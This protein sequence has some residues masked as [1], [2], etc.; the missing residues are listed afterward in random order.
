MSVRALSPRAPETTEEMISDLLAMERRFK[1][2]YKQL[3]L[4]NNSLE[5]LKVRL[6]RAVKQGSKCFQSIL[7]DRIAT[8]EEV[9]TAF[10]EFS[11]RYA[12]EMDAMEERLRA[13]H[14]IDWDDVSS[15]RQAYVNTQ[16]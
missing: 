5:S 12:A 9:R 10:M 16:S 1:R 6:D 7:R 8:V 2:S 11:S 4:L 3:V 13:E 14:D 15:W